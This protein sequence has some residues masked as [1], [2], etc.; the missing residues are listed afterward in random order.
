MRSVKSQ[1]EHYAKLLK[2]NGQA[3]GLV[4]KGKSLI[5]RIDTWEENLIQPKQ[6]T[7]QDVINY[8]NQLNAE[9]MEL[10]SY[11]DAAEP[12]VTQG[13]KERLTDLLAFWNTYA[14]ERDA[15]V[16]TEMNDYNETYKTLGLPAVI[17]SE[18]K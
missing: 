16:K 11:V 14:S 8:H 7:F 10:K 6:K 5:K 9:F 18:N 12:K 4:E 17:L 1:L 15:I 3:K 13:A 2:E